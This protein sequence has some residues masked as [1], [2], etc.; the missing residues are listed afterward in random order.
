VIHVIPSS[1]FASL[2]EN[3][4]HYAT[5]KSNALCRGRPI[6]LTVYSAVSEF[7]RPLFA[8][9]RHVKG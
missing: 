5:K 4:A 1:A 2:F 9:I 6:G 7:I 3:E 8:K